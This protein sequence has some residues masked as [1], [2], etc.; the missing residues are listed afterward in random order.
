M[1]GDRDF[2]TVITA[3]VDSIGRELDV[4]IDAGDVKTIHLHEVVRCLRRSYYDRT[5]PMDVKRGGFNE[6]LSGLLQK[7]GYGSE[8]KDFEV[9]GIRLRGRA[10]MIVD[11]AIVLFRSADALPEDPKAGDVLFL[12][13]CLWI[14]NKFDGVIVY[15]SG[16]RREASFSVTRNNKVF[17]ETIRRVRVLNDLLEQKKVPILEPATECERCQY[18]ERCFMKEKVGKSF[19]LKEM[20][21]MNPKEE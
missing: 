5:D 13:A 17:E 3:A 18:Y 2:R 20:I 6:L 19:N 16:D 9:D 1:M 10:D 7:Y 12:N 15:I 14:Y 8:P 11:D 4:K 21:G